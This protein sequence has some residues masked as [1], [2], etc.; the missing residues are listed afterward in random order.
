MK[1]LFA[2]FAGEEEYPDLDIDG[3]VDRLSRAIQCQTV[4][5]ADHSLTDFAPFDALHAHMRASYPHVMAS[6]SFEEIGH[7]VLITIPGSD[8][9]LLPCLY[10]SHQDVVPVIAGTEGD[11]RYGPF[12]GAVAEGYIWGRGALDIKQQVFGVLEAA[13]YLL[14][15]GKSFRRTAYLAFGDDEETLNLG[16]QAIAKTLEERGVRLAFVL[17]EG[18]GK[19]ESGGDFGAPGQALA[20]IDL[21]EKGYADLEV[22]VESQGGHSSRP[23]GG[24]SLEHLARA[25]TRICDRPFPTRLPALLRETFRALAPYITEEPL[26]TLV[27]DVDGNAEAIAAW[28]AA[29]PAT[30]AYT[31]TTIAPTMIQ[32]GSA[33]CNVMPQTMQAVINFRLSAGETV[34]SLFSHCREAVGDSPVTMRFL[35]ANDP[36]RVSR[37]DGFG[38]ESLVECMKHFYPEV[39]FVPSMTVGATDARR[40]E[41]ICD[42]CLRLSP[43]FTEAE[44]V[45]VGV[46]G[47][48]ERLPIRS[49]AQ[50]IR[51]L[52]RLMERANVQAEEKMA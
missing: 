23:F 11:W 33:A 47:T 8:E 38:Y 27:Q 16:A 21:M 26:K 10:M 18:G 37:W 52:I 35:Q 12:S 13:E 20:L 7:A 36:S 31:T 1:P 17:D 19:L 15:H 34:E 24:T 14:S 44:D 3:A 5:F 30:F 45:R 32:G 22:T 43:F 4:N 28:C 9:S 25:I 6:G 49:Y 40:Y 39:V 2:Y 48:N 42:S 50:G 41:G 46:H 29:R 51:V